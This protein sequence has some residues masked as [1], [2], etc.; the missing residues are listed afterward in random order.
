MEPERSAFRRTGNGGDPRLKKDND[1]QATT[2]GDTTLPNTIRTHELRE[3]LHLSTQPLLYQMSHYQPHS[4]LRAMEKSRRFLMNLYL[5]TRK[6]IPTTMVGSLSGI[7]P[8]KL[9]TSTTASLR[10]CSGRILASQTQPPR[11]QRNRQHL[12]YPDLKTTRL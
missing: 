4:R 12:V 10:L 9:S 6:Q 8:H 1:P 5:Q 7:K 11:Y 3:A 2:P